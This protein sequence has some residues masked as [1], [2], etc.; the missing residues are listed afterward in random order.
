MSDNTSVKSRIRSLDAFK[1]FAIV[2][3]VFAHLV[4]LQPVAGGAVSETSV[5]KNTIIEYLY[6]GLIMFFAISG[7]FY[8]ANE[9]FSEKVKKRLIKLF[10][11]LV[12]AIV[13]LTTVMYLYLLVLG[14]DITFSAYWDTLINGLTGGGGAFQPYDN[15]TSN[16]IS[17]CGIIAGYYFIEV[18]LTSTILYYVIGRWAL[19]DIPHTIATIL[20]LLTVS[21]LCVEVIGVKLPYYLELT[22]IATSAMLVGSTYRRYSLAERMEAETFS[23]KF[24]V[25]F[26][27]ALVVGVLLCYSDLRSDLGFHRSHFGLFGGWSAYTIFLISMIC[28]FTHLYIA[29]LVSKIPYLS[30]FLIFFAKYSLGI[31]VLSTFFCKILIAPFV[32]IPTD[33]TYPELSAIQMVAVGTMSVVLCVITTILFRRAVVKIKEKKNVVAQ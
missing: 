12:L 6:V 25:S 13:V 18:L 3:I 24:V 15:T 16:D 27:I 29:T 17:E 33:F 7:Y 8:D 31:L 23:S 19:R 32:T 26:I 30:D 4:L 22:P 11:V 21:M 14:Y 1:G 9:G 20:V 5:I 10:V 28:G 2:G